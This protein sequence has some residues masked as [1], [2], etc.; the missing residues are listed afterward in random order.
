MMP[1]SPKCPSYQIPQSVAAAVAVV[2]PSL[3]SLLSVKPPSFNPTLDSSLDSL[4]HVKPPS[5]N[6]IIDSHRDDLD[7]KPP[8]F[9][10]TL[11]SHRDKFLSLSYT[12]L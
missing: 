10:H 12:N 5:F 4:L 3:G 1:T 7:V 8:T 9:Y 6:P 2:D 11:D